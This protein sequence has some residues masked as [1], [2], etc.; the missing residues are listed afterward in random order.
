MSTIEGSQGTLLSRLFFFRWAERCYLRKISH[1][2]SRHT[3]GER[4]TNFLAAE[5]NRTKP[6]SPGPTRSLRSP[7]LTCQG[8]WSLPSLWPAAAAWPAKIRFKSGL[9]RGGRRARWRLLPSL[10]RCI[11]RPR[12]PS[13]EALRGQRLLRQPH[14]MALT[15]NK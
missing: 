10:P 6:P 3:V 9:L 4:I 2:N 15:R 13:G 7:S 8:T 5:P 1:L 14:L 11:L 12:L